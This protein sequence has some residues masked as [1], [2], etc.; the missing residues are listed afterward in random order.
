MH[1]VE[2]LAS[3]DPADAKSQARARITIAHCHIELAHL[4]EL[5]NF[6]SPLYGDDE[7]PRGHRQQAIEILEPFVADH[8]KVEWLRNMLARAQCSLNEEGLTPRQI[9]ERAIEMLKRLIAENPKVSLYP[10]MLKRA[11]SEL[12]QEGSV[13]REVEHVRSK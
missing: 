3:Q 8:P 5:A 9:E 6:Y 4:Y 11:H 13:P 10:R 12:N 1:G 7:R 2:I